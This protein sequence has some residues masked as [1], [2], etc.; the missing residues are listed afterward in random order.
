MKI[1]FTTL[2]IEIVAL[3]LLYSVNI[4]NK[5]SEVGIDGRERWSFCPCA[6]SR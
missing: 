4:V 2:N 3:L 1:I 6:V 5:A